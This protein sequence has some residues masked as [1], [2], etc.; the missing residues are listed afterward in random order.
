MELGAAGLGDA[1]TLLFEE[2]SG[3]LLL[4]GPEVAGVFEEVVSLS[5]AL[6]LRFFFLHGPVV[7]LRRKSLMTNRRATR[8]GSI[9]FAV[10]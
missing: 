6:R 3:L 5:T 8:V 9:L 10:I 4:P 2:L 7:S 1:R